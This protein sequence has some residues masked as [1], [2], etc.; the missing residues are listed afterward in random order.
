MV[1]SGPDF[2]GRPRGG[3]TGRGHMTRRLPLRRAGMWMIREATSETPGDCCNWDPSSTRFLFADR[4]HSTDFRDCLFLEKGGNRHYSTVPRCAVALRA[5]TVSLKGPQTRKWRGRP[6]LAISTPGQARRSGC[7]PSGV[8]GPDA[9]ATSGGEP[10]V[11]VEMVDT[12]LTPRALYD[13]YW[14]LRDM[15]A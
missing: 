5:V 12:D 3:S 6:A 9:L 14:G 11:L 10:Q 2:S 15:R 7:F 1:E 4:I 8:Q 13:T